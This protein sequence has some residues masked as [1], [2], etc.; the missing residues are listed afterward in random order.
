MTI[1]MPRPQTC[2]LC[3]ART[4]VPSLAS[5]STFGAYDLDL[6]PPPMH[7]HTMH[8]W[9]QRCPGCG[10]CA[11]HL[12]RADGV[13]PAWIRAVDYRALLD[14]PALPA[15]AATFLAAALLAQQRQALRDAFWLTLNAAWACD[16]H[17]ADAPARASRR[18]ALDRM[19]AVQAHGGHCGSDAETDA[20]LRLDLLR[21]SGQFDEALTHAATL[22]P[23]SD[24]ALR[25]A[26][27]QAER[28]ALQDAACYTSDD[29]GMMAAH[30]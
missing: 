26:A 10:Y 28:A 5:T 20:L 23:R 27:F 9:V 30:V 2:A 16:D 21:R 14:D 17:P 1:L 22:R 3:G 15:L 19:D 7:R 29:A 6:R 18:L 24:N 25:I 11:P 13:D 4:E 12:G 8:S